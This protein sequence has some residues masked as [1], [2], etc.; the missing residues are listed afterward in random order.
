VASQL[1]RDEPWRH[2][3][4]FQVRR[5]TGRINIDV[6]YYSKFTVNRPLWGIFKMFEAQGLEAKLE[7]NPTMTV[8][9]LGCGEGRALLELQAR[10]PRASLYCVNLPAYGQAKGGGGGASLSGLN[11][12]RT[13]ETIKSVVQYYNISWNPDTHN[14]PRV[15]Y[16]DVTEGD[17]P[18][19]S[20][21][22]DI[23]FSRAVVSKF[24]IDSRFLQG[25]VHTLAPTGEALIHTDALYQ[26]ECPALNKPG[27]PPMVLM[28]RRLKVHG[29]KCMKL[30][31]QYSDTTR[32]AGG[33][34]FEVCSYYILALIGACDDTSY[35]ECDAG[36]E[37]AG[38]KLSGA[39]R[40]KIPP[41]T[42]AKFEDLY[43]WD[44]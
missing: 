2:D 12:D 27:A 29:N 4:Q 23:I 11:K 14:T 15:L 30:V 13:L 24:T 22:V 16:A 20:G 8:L 7:A 17:L 37:A 3:E 1:L 35:G 28:C 34:L 25:L 10:F 31:S 32:V 43:A 18:L 21:F 42:T 5:S 44:F 39:C 38:A 6:Q 36:L 26:P 41:R 40:K 33:R 9:E 19:P